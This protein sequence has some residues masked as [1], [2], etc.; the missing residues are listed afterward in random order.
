[1]DQEPLLSISEERS[2]TI[3]GLYNHKSSC[4][5]FSDDDVTI[6]ISG[7][8]PD[9]ILSYQ[10]IQSWRTGNTSW[11]LTY[12]DSSRKKQIFMFFPNNPNTP[13]YCTRLIQK[14]VSDLIDRNDNL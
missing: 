14:F 11:Q 6:H 4:I 9:L 8:R 12:L 5:T 1:M 7:N 13:K 3:H 2:I 10:Q